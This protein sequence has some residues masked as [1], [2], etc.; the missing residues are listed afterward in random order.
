MTD[1]WAAW[2]CVWPS[3]REGEPMARWKGK[4]GDQED[5][6]ISMHT[7]TCKFNGKPDFRGK[8]WYVRW[9]QLIKWTKPPAYSSV[10]D[11]FVS[12]I[13]LLYSW[14]IMFI[15]E[16]LR[17]TSPAREELAFLAGSCNENLKSCC[18]LHVYSQWS[19]HHL[20][21]MCKNDIC[22]LAS[23]GGFVKNRQD[24]WHKPV[25][26]TSIR[27]QYINPINCFYIS[28][29][30]IAFYKMICLK[31]V[32]QIKIIKVYMCKRG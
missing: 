23:E 31:I 27:D 2:K 20:I 3:E 1:G 32:W 15:Q 19:L 12:L 16:L 22:M 18:R 9:E 11:V 28:L 6:I 25:V 21:S 4:K 13:F 24:Y 8:W 17:V 14:K 10:F 7:G 5:Q 29:T 26:M 30:L